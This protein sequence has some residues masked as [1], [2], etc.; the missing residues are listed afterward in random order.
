[1]VKLK[2]LDCKIRS[3]NAGPFW[4]TID[5]FCASEAV[6]QC[7]KHTNSM[8]A[9]AIGQVFLVPEETVKLFHLDLLQ[10]IKIS[11][12]RPQVQGSVA[13]RDMHAGQQYVRLLNLDIKYN[14]EY[15]L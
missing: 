6:Y 2:N 11:F 1:M 4:L 12:P 15:V 8:T 10:V 14:Q 9:H 13:D 5:I 3:K 7:L